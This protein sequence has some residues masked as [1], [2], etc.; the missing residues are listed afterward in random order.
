M[1]FGNAYNPALDVLVKEIGEVPLANGRDVVEVAIRRMDKED[2]TEGK[3]RVA[4]T[5]ISNGSYRNA[6]RRLDAGDAV[7]VYKVALAAATWLAKH[8]AAPVQKVAAKS[9]TKVLAKRA[10]KA[11]GRR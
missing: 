8:Q 6:T 4:L 5:T 1:A 11:A 2:G 3:A 9:I 7:E 10:S